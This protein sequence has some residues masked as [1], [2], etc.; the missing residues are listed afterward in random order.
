MESEAKPSCSVSSSL[1]SG[2]WN[3]CSFHVGCCLFQLQD[4]IFQKRQGAKPSF[5][6]ISLVK[7]PRLQTK[8]QIVVGVEN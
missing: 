2:V 4:L 5:C 3:K 1:S 6:K 8:R 7:K